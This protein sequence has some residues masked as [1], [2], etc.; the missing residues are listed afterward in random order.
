MFKYLFASELT[1]L[2]LSVHQNDLISMEYPD[3][4]SQSESLSCQPFFTPTNRHAAYKSHLC[5]CLV[6]IRRANKLQVN[7][8]AILKIDKLS[9][10]GSTA[11]I[12]AL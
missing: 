4:I 6:S 7:L 10:P 9:R 2:N 8:S 12:M 3:Y 1:R 11:N 5:W